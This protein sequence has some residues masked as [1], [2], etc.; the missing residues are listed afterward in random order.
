V[1]A[2]KDFAA[3]AREHSQDGSAASGGDLGFFKQGEMVGPFNDVAFSLEP[4]K[5]SGV[6]ETPFGYHII[7]VAQ[8]LPARDVPLDE[9]RPQ[10]EEYLKNQNRE[11][12]TE[13]F[14]NSLKAKG[15]VEILV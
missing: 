4:G 8:K 15:K 2:G 3:L 12:E 13:A 11:T 5:T 7:K 6:V 14:V 10:V 1:K 9:V